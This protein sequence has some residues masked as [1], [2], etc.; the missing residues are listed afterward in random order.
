MVV[1]GVRAVKRGEGIKR[2]V[3]K[4]V[5]VVKGKGTAVKG[6]GTVVK[7]GIKGEEWKKRGRRGQ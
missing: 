6:E 3:V 2:V 7:G 4:G 1:K 5:R